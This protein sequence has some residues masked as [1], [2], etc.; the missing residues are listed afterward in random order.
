MWRRDLLLLFLFE[1]FFLLSFWFRL[2][3]YGYAELIAFTVGPLLYLF[4]QQ[5]NNISFFTQRHAVL[6]S[7]IVTFIGGMLSLSGLVLFVFE[8]FPRLSGLFKGVESYTVY[9]NTLAFFLIMAIP[10]SIFLAIAL[11]KP[12][13]QKII[14]LF[15]L[16]IQLSALFLTFSRGALI[17]FV[18]A[19]IVGA[20]LSIR[21]YHKKR[22]L[23]FILKKGLGVVFF[24]IA[25]LFFS[26]AMNELHRSF[27]PPI[28]HQ[29]PLTED[30]VA[31]FSDRQTS[32]DQS[33]DERLQFWSNSFQLI[34]L[35]P[36]FG[37]GSDGFRFQYPRFQSELLATSTHPHNLFLKIA[38]E[39][40]LPAAFFLFLFF[41]TIGVDVLWQI[42]KQKDERSFFWKLTLLF[43]FVAALLHSQMDYN[44]NAMLPWFLFWLIVSNLPL[45]FKTIKIKNFWAIFSYMIIMTGTLFLFILSLA[46]AWNY[47]LIKD[48]QKS[49]AAGD[50]KNFE[51]HM[52]QSYSFP[53]EPLRYELLS[54]YIHKTGRDGVLFVYPYVR[55]ALERYPLWAELRIASA[56]LSFAE[57]KFL[58]A[59]GAYEWGL[60]LNGLNNFSW[61]VEYIQ[62]LLKAEFFQRMQVKE[63][64]YFSLLSSYSRKLRL[65]EHHTV[66][67]SNPADAYQ[68]LVLYFHF[69]SLEGK[70]D[71]Y[72][73]LQEYQ[74]NWQLER[75]KFQELFGVVVKP[76]VAAL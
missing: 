30:V 37:V 33:T 35:Y 20:F 72:K 40:G 11:K 17:A 51:L 2:Q 61:H 53:F 28:G 9:P 49:L 58:E 7:W 24:L 54:E 46:Y 62:S 57:G 31:R 73:L 68:L 50:N 71:W 21:F 34:R 22:T 14:S 36:W 12:L 8:Q 70:H 41:L 5:Q 26:F 42:W 56:R 47:R 19:G 55:F 4:F 60:A 67:T 18:F 66:A 3:P 29:V 15:L 74:Y 16:G 27:Q 39:N 48:A 13:W 25:V 76:P 44:L 65:N 32:A 59:T 23:L 75:Y 45:D 69:F 64:F 10:F 6:I 52:A 43:A 1:I 63:D 38:V